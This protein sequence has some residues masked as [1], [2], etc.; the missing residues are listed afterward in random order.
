MIAQHD[1]AAKNTFVGVDY[2][3]DELRRRESERSTARVVALTEVLVRLTRVLVGLTVV[4]VGLTVVIV[5]LTL[6]LLSKG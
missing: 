6:V 5:L 2:Y 4:L 3:L 1:A